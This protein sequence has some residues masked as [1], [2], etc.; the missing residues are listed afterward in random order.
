MRLHR[1]EQRQSFPA[2]MDR[3][4]DFFADPRNLALVTPP[5]MRLQITS[6]LPERVY[7]GLLITYRLRP[8]AGVPVNWVNEITHVER[9]HRWID[10]Q[11]F[12]PYR[13]FQHQ[14]HFREI[15]GGVEML[16]LVHYAMPRGAGP[17]GRV[18]VARAL[19]ALFAYRGQVLERHLGAWNG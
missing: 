16:D 7:A 14:H 2:P 6:E 19:R 9:P 10:E 12:G 3:V 11:R 17:V 15:E 13:F 8:I 18:M 5:E 1:L 4:W